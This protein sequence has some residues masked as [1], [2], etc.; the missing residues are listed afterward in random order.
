MAD[1][2]AGRGGDEKCFGFS[3]GMDVENV[4][5]SALDTKTDTIQR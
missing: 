2:Q 3:A 5:T 4:V 1:S